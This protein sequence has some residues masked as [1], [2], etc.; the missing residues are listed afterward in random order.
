MSDTPT[1]PDFADILADA[2]DDVRVQC[3]SYCIGGSYNVQQAVSLQLAAKVR[4][5]CPCVRF[6]GQVPG[7]MRGSSWAF[8]PCDHREAPTVGVLLGEAA[9]ARIAKGYPLAVQP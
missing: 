1:I 8:V 2:A 4:E 9:A 3:G 5:L 7:H 6:D